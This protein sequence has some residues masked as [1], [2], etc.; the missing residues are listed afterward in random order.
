MPALSLTEQLLTS[1][2]REFPRFRMLPKANSRL[3]VAIDVLLRG[4]TFGR[5]SRFL[6]HY[7]TALGETLYLAPSWESMCDRDRVI[8]LRHERVHLRQRR[9]YGSFVMA[10]LYLW[11][12]LPVGLALGRA[13]LEWEAYEETLIAT[14]E[15]Y[16]VEALDGSTLKDWLVARFVGPDYGYMWPF[17]NQVAKW[18]EATKQRIRT[19]QETLGRNE[20]P[21][22][23]TRAG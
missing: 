12:I 9:R 15:L 14:A 17:P 3:C 18:Y 1:I 11:P 19:R 21:M 23:E 5:L 10:L 22:N 16:G 7:H 20:S 6:S 8:L 2:Q 4:L 13:R